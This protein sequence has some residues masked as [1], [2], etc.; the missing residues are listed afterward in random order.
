MLIALILV[1]RCLLVLRGVLDFLCGVWRAVSRMLRAAPRRRKRCLESN[2]EEGA[3]KTKQVRITA[4]FCAWVRSDDNQ[5]LLDCRV[6]SK[7]TRPLAPTSSLLYT[8]A[9]VNFTIT[10]SE[11]RSFFRRI[12][13]NIINPETLIG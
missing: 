11:N 12:L 8:I 6:I 1:L 2:S 5:S 13:T 3:R 4:N 9:Q 7:K 10:N